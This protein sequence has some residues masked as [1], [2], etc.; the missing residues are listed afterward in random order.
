[1]P[2]LKYETDGFEDFKFKFDRVLDEMVKKY[3]IKTKANNKYNLDS[4][5]RLRKD[6]INFLKHAI[7]NQTKMNKQNTPEKG[8]GPSKVIYV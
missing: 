8:R 6:R 1:M 4:R 2:C 5:N 3:R 7:R